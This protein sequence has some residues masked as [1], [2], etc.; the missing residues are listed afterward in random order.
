MSLGRR[1][2][3]LMFGLTLLGMIGAATLPAA[4]AAE[5]H[6][7]DVT[8]H[9]TLPPSGGKVVR[10]RFDGCAAVVVRT[11][12]SGGSTW[13]D[14]KTYNGTKKVDCGSGN[15]LSI[16]FKVTVAGCSTTSSGSWQVRRGTGRF[17]SAEGGG[18]LV[19]TYT[20][21]NGPGTWCQ[22]DGINDRYVGELRY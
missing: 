1:G 8:V 12:R 21:Q 6:A 7:L 4:K 15:S 11:I 3:S 16:S 19:G 17:A 5:I 2:K 10:G 20:Y 14:V 18:K 9:E 22:A 13:G